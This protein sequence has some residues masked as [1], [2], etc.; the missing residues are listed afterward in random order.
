MFVLYCIHMGE[1]D[2]LVF[3]DIETTGASARHGRVLEVAAL[4]YERGQ[5]SQQF[6]TL[7]DPEEYVPSFI[8]RLTGI[9]QQDVAGKPKFREIAGELLAVMS[10]AVF[11]AHN[12]WFDYRF[13]EHEFARVGVDFAPPLGCTVQ[14]SRRF[15]PE[16]RSHRLDAVIERH[17]I[18]IEDRHRALGDAQALVELYEKLVGQHG[19]ALVSDKLSPRRPLAHQRSI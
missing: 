10:G 9:E 12:V 7:L 6:A 5:V 4:R 18:H 17:G 16:H 11:I 8:T 2:S 19:E 1:S 14:L 15:N 13:L 3:V